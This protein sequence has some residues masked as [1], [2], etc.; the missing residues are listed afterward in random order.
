MRLNEARGGREAGRR[1]SLSIFVLAVMLLGGCVAPKPRPEISV[2]LHAQQSREML[3]GEWR[4][5]GF[6][7]R[8]SVSGGGESGSG[9]IDWLRR[10]ARLEVVMQAPVSRRSWRLVDDV[11]GASLE[12]LDGGTRYG[13][14][15]E[16]L[17]RNELGWEL[18][19]AQV[20]AWVRGARS[21]ANAML[22][23]DQNG[24]PQRMRDGSWE[25]EYR[26][27]GTGWVA[28]PKRIFA[29]SASDKFR[30]IV[31]NWQHPEP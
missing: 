17:L 2:S 21:G 20:E 9:R 19:V 15:A 16:S 13:S 12:G 31:D 23:F 5:W 29:E 22:E 18:P 7:G 25:I 8:I 4:E 28:L 1:G 26:G 10:G 30:L 3:L 6:S 24:L 11:G 14:D 27:W